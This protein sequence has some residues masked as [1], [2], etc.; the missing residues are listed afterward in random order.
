MKK[1]GIMT[2]FKHNNYGTVLQAYA[3]Q[4]KINLLGNEAEIINYS[5][6]I[7]KTMFHEMNFHFI[8]KKLSYEFFHQRYHQNNSNTKKLFDDFRNNYLNISKEC[9]NHNELKQVGESYDKIVCG[10]DQIW[11]PNFFENNLVEAYI[12]DQ[13]SNSDLSKLHS[14]RLKP[15]YDKN[16]KIDS[17]LL[18]NPHGLADQKISFDDI[19]DKIDSISFSKI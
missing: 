9:D 2:W 19:F 18:K 7:R 17:Y 5:T 15:I 4:K 10:S 8:I 6:R 16:G 3:L 1:I 14:Y 12:G 11:N 13:H